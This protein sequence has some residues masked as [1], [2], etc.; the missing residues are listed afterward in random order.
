MDKYVFFYSLDGWNEVETL[1]QLKAESKLITGGIKDVFYQLTEPGSYFNEGEGYMTWVISLKHPPQI[2][3][4]LAVMY[5]SDCEGFN[6][7]LVID[8]IEIVP[9]TSKFDCDYIYY[10]EDE[11]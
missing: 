9:A 7:D 4:A 2:G 8:C 3:Q 6:N 11:R 5:L 10:L 1:E